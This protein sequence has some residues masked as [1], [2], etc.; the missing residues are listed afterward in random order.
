MVSLFNDATSYYGHTASRKVGAL[1]LYT[2]M[3]HSSSKFG[4]PD[5]AV[6][7]THDLPFRRRAR[8]HYTNGESVQALIS[9]MSC[10]L[11]DNSV[12]EWRGPQQA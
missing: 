7:W 1:P 8:Y 4:L 6:I 5:P 2:E 10:S 12:Y 11:W 3:G 9:M